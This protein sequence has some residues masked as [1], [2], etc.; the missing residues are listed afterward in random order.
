MAGNPS[1][2]KWDLTNWT[3]GPVSLFEALGIKKGTIQYPSL[4][5]ELTQ[6]GIST[7]NTSSGS[8]GSQSSTP[9]DNASQPSGSCTAGQISENKALGQQLATSAGWT[10]AQWDA[11]NNIV[12][13][14]SGWCNTAQ[15]SSSTAYGIGQFLNT[16]WSSTGYTK[17]S[18]PKTQILAMLA[19]I[20][21]RYGDPS[22]AWSFHQA[23]GWYLCLIFSVI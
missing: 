1:A 5:A 3:A 20:K 11:L 22:S 10:G 17:T 6:K 19:Y 7:S 21:I 12:M 15:N 4:Q 18:S 23:N 14:E 2:S 13:A 9:A 16:T 8:G